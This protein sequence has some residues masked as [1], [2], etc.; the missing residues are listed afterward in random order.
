MGVKGKLGR[1]TAFFRLLFFDLSLNC[2]GNVGGSGAHND[3][4][5]TTVDRPDSMEMRRMYQSC[6][7][8]GAKVLSSS[9]SSAAKWM[10]SR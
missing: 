7:A 4:G 5:S 9:S 3:P 2:L 10:A 8:S 1:E 6:L